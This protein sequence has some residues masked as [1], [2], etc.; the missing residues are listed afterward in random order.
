MGQ[1]TADTLSALKRVSSKLKQFRDGYASAPLVL[2]DESLKV[3][4]STISQAGQRLRAGRRHLESIESH[5]R[6]ETVHGNALPIG[7]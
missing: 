4:M 3:I 6:K 5:G 1:E 7:N 2:K